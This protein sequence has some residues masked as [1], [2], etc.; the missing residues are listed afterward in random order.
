MKKAL[1]LLP[2]LVM[3]LISAILVSTTTYA[4]FSMNDNV[5]AQN[6]KVKV[7]TEDGIVISNVNKGVWSDLANGTNT[8]V[9]IVPTSN[10]VTDDPDASPWVHAMSPQDDNANA[11]LSLGGTYEDLAVN[12]TVN[13]AN[14]GDEGLGFVDR[15]NNNGTYE[16][17]TDMPVVLLNNFFIKSASTDYTGHLY[18][19][20]VNVVPSNNAAFTKLDNGARVLI[21]LT[22]SDNTTHSFLFAPVL[23]QASATTTTSY[24]W[25]N[26][27]AVAAR[28]VGGTGAQSAYDVDT[29]ITFIPNAVADAINVKVYFY[30]EGEDANVKSTNIAQSV[31]INDLELTIHFGTQTVH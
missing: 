12:W 27:T 16:A 9:E 4:W 21:V 31:T 8:A 3:L 15:I 13:T 10:Y 29:G 20:D 1:K 28:Y 19:N 23:N 26:T 24:T 30:Y 14:G 25:K 7:H 18:I 22:E 11:T 6:M 2:A 17:G 5:T